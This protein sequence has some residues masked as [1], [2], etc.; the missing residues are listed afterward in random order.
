MRGC[1]TIVLALAAAFCI[2]VAIDGDPCDRGSG[3]EDVFY[4]VGLV[5]VGG[6]TY[7]VARG[8]TKRVWILATAAVLTPVAVGF[9]ISVI[10]L[11]RWV[12]ECSN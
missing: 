12:G 1:L 8:F 3:V 2:G 11:L 9:G 7:V 5:L 6:A 10:S 4:G